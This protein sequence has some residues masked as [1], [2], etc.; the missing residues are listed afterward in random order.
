MLELALFDALFVSLI[1]IFITQFDRFI[2]EGFILSSTVD[3]YEC[4]VARPSIPFQSLS[5]SSQIT[6]NRYFSSI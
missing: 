4:R 6:A 5:Y 2:F 3:L 1:V